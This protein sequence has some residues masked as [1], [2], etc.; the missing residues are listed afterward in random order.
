MS[1]TTCLNSEIS[2]K[3][4]GEKFAAEEERDTY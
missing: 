4:W 3:V 2:P 1:A